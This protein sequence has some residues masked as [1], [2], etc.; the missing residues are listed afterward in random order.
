MLAENYEVGLPLVIRQLCELSNSIS[1]TWLKEE[2]GLVAYEAV[3]LLC[4]DSN[5]DA[6]AEVAYQ[7]LV[8]MNEVKALKTPEGVAIWLEIAT[9]LKTRFPPGV[10]HKD[11][12][13]SGKEIGTVAKILHSVQLE[14]DEP[15]SASGTRQM[16]PHFAWAV[17]LKH[18]MNTTFASPEVK[19]KMM[20]S[21]HFKLKHTARF[22][23]LWI[24]TVDSEYHTK[25][26]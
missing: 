9:H 2:C 11:N 5:P 14:D 10:W 4:Q 18:S 7:V 19:E 23:Q 12:P 1:W 6:H 8:A 3:R 13:L 25:I 24:E 26:T 16:K 20:K 22:G 21:D 15:T 17:I